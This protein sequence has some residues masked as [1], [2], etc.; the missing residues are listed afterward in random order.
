MCMWG[1]CPWSEECYRFPELGLQVVG[2]YWNMRT[3]FVSSG[4]AAIFI[5][6]PFLQLTSTPL[7]SRVLRLVWN[8][9]CRQGGPGTHR[10]PLPSVFRVLESKAC[11]S[12]SQSVPSIGLDSCWSSFISLLSSGGVDTWIKNFFNGKNAVQTVKLQGH[13]DYPMLSYIT[14]LH[15]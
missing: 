14:R 10:D 15:K 6:E 12:K 5:A 4:R 7:S 3:K 2:N 1:Q 9:L 8:L 13:V 11:A